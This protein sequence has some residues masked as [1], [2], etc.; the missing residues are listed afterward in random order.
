MFISESAVI[1]LAS[2][3]L[4]VAALFQVFDGAQVICMGALRGLS[5]V[6]VPILLAFCGY[7]LISIPVGSFIAFGLEKGS[8]GIWIGM[9][10]GLTFAAIALCTRFRIVTRVT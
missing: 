8:M 7:W 1:L 3:L 2:Q 4:V 10:L 6:R 5:D 9:I